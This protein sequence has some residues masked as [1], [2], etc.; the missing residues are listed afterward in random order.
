MALTDDA[1]TLIR[2]H[3]FNKEKS[4][5]I[6]ATCGN[7]HDI[8]FLAE[9]GFSKVMGFDI[10]NIAI[11]AC[12]ERIKSADLK[13]VELIL[14]GHQSLERYIRTPVDCVMFNFGYLPNG[15]KSLTTTTD[16]SIA[17]LTAATKLL[18][19]EG[20][21]S[22]MCYPGHPSGKSETQAIKHWF[23]TLNHQWSVETHL[24]VS[25]K[26][27][28]PILFTLTRQKPKPTS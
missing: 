17:A 25:P 22:L 16:T 20:L 6:D 3:F 15:D 4:L 21:I 24:A 13:N 26:P 5:A 2:D 19:Q 14:D 7:G 9:L 28:A 23:S 11:Q 18:N 10:Q 27:S 12:R 8:Q 1:H